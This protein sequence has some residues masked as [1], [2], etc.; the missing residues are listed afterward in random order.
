MQDGDTALQLLLARDGDQAPALPEGLP[1]GAAQAPDHLE[2]LSAPSVAARSATAGDMPDDVPEPLW[3]I[4]APEGP[5]G[6]R[7]IELIRPLVKLREEAQGRPAPVFRVPPG[8]AAMSAADALRWRS[9]VYDTGADLGLDRAGFQLVLGD[10]DQ[11]PLA[12]QQQQARDAAVGRLAFADEAGYAAYAAKVIAAEKAARAPGRLVLH[13]AHDGSRAL[14]M[15][16]DGIAQPGEALVRAEV[17]HGHVPVASV[18]S[19]GQPSFPGREELLEQATAPGPGVLL[20]LSHGLGPPLGG[21]ASPAAQRARQGALVLGTG[22]PLGGDEVAARAFMPGGLWMMFACFGAGTPAASAYAFWME[23]LAAAGRP[24]PDLRG[25]LAL[26]QPFIAELPQR[27]L[28]NPDGPLGFIGHVDLAWTYSFRQ[29]NDPREARPGRFMRVLA[30]ALSGKPLGS[31]F[32][33]L[34][35]FVAETDAAL[36]GAYADE[37]ASP[38]GE[39]AAQ[40][41]ARLWMT[42]QD[43]AGF[44]LLGDP[45]VRLP[46]G[47]APRPDAERLARAVEQVL[48]GQPPAQ[49]AA[50]HGVDPGAL[51]QAV[52]AFRAAGR[53]ALGLG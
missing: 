39:A 20:T 53:R 6:D 30:A 9:R 22:E 13:T 32:G 41:R 31:A 12:I 46:V 28:A 17:A 27:A 8:S 44:I 35:S 47:A 10:L 24:V 34:S 51:E 52:A 4:I 16:Y 49:A 38:G 48:G 36:A 42:R 7:L 23:R 50:E 18:S 14:Q 26:A 45:A 3:A 1:A 25:A 29:E 19:Y 11:V 15:A 2:I 37:A 33:E 21:W 40:H 5:A 43:L